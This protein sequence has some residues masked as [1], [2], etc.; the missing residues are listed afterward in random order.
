M[1]QWICLRLP[2]CCP[3]FKSQAYH[4]CFHQFLFELC[5]E[6][7]TKIK[8]HKEAGIWPNFLKKESQDWK[9]HVVGAWPFESNKNV[10]SICSDNL[11]YKCTIVPSP[12][13]PNTCSLADWGVS[14]SMKKKF[15]ARVA[16]CLVLASTSWIKQ[17]ACLEDVCLEFF[18]S[19]HPRKG[20]FFQMGYPQPLFR[21]INNIDL[22]QINVKNIHLLKC[23]GIQTHN[24]STIRLFN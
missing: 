16:P 10:F 8:K 3:G 11:Q 22:H 5:Q 19:C 17:T 23:A 4:L 9:V 21:S 2:S 24:L 15:K 1:A 14:L 12:P 13:H 7:K 18:L 6:K 20:F